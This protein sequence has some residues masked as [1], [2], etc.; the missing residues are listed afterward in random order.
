[1]PKHLVSW[2]IEIEAPDAVA[3]AQA[4]WSAMRAPL[5]AANVFEV[6]AA[7]GGESIVVDLEAVAAEIAPRPRPALRVVK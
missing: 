5:S 2:Y 6:G 1:M 3:A 7:D 4:A